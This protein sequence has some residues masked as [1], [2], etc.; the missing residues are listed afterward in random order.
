[1]NRNIR[2]MI[3]LLVVA[4]AVTL[5]GCGNQYPESVMLC[6]G[7]VN[8]WV[9]GHLTATLE[10][11]TIG[12][13]ISQDRISLTGNSFQGIDE[14]KVCRIGSIEFARK[15]ELFFDSGGCSMK[16]KSEVRKYGT[17]NVITR[18]LSFSEHFAPT[19]M[20]WSDGNYECSESK[21]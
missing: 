6:Q 2:L 13:R 15:D 11:Q 8:T 20:T 9:N 14:Q 10:N 16:N 7:S 3:W 17:Y 1:M 19:G 18:H 21:R 4:S 12:M 5:A